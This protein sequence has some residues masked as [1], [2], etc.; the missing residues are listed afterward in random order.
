M[1]KLFHNIFM[2][3]LKS[4]SGVYCRFMKYVLK[5]VRAIKSGGVA[6]FLDNWVVLGKNMREV[7]CVVGWVWGLVKTIF[8]R[9][10][11]GIEGFVSAFMV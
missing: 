2:R 9:L 1:F 4:N 5:T 8:F 3:V 11:R 7:V 10:G 6:Q